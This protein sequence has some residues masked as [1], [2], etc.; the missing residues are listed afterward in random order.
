[1][2]SSVVYTFVPIERICYSCD[3][4]IVN[5]AV[6]LIVFNSAVISYTPMTFNIVSKHLHKIKYLAQYS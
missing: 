1:M 5:Q 3:Q 6:C 2:V 4:L